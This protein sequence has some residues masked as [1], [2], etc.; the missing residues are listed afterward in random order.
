[1]NTDTLVTKALEGAA[2]E[3]AVTAKLYLNDLTIR[4]CQA[5]AN[6]PREGYCVIRDGMDTVYE[7]LE[8]SD[9]IIIGSPA[10]FG[11]I[12][13]QLKLVIDRSNC[14]T[15][16]VTSPDGR[17]T[18]RR[19]LSRAKKGLFIWV[20]DLS[21]DPRHALAEVRLWCRDANIN[22][23]DYLV[24]TRSDRDPPARERADILQT[25]FSLGS[26]LVRDWR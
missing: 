9:A 22:L 12:S 17:I 11:T 21:T 5:C 7:V 25:A 6:P 1:M 2:S 14:L 24:V 20:A 26:S 23:V 10:Y 13:A 8:N 19:K 15:E 4:P 18:F 16:M 3:G